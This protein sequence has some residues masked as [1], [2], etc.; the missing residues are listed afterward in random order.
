MQ[1]TAGP[2]DIGA[3]RDKLNKLGL[4]AVQI[5]SFGAPTDV[6]IRVEQQPGGDARAAG[7]AEEGRAMRCGAEYMQRR[8][9]VVGPGGFGRAAA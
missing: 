9:E 8:V 6:L 7:G 4:G 5:Q 1:S 3:L 2:A